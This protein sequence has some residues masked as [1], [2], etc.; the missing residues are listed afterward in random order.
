MTVTGRDGMTSMSIGRATRART[1]AVTIPGFPNL[2]CLYGPNT[3]IVINGS[4]IYFSGAGCGTSSVASASCSKASIARSMCAPTCTTSS[5]SRS[6]AENRAD[7]VGW[8][9]PVTAGT[10]NEH[11]HV[12]Q[13]LAVHSA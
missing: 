8:S 13:E 1:S 10:R 7:G 4:I 5:T 6:D 12:A 11:G 2:F 3:N 9:E